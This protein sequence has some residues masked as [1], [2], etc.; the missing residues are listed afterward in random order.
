ME[1]K[2]EGEG[3]WVGGDGRRN[4]QRGDSDFSRF[5]IRKK[6]KKS[7]KKCFKKR[8]F[9]SKRGG[10]GGRSRGRWR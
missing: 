5:S 10:G 6:I 7:P 3:A 2:G 4:L 1:G 8:V 9:T